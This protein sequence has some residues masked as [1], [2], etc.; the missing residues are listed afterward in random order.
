MIRRLPASLFLALLSAATLFA[1]ADGAWLAKVPAGDHQKTNPYQA[2]PDAIAAGRNIFE[3]HCSKCH[4][5]NA[6][7]RKKRPSLRSQRVQQQAT[8][9]DLHW[10]LVNGS[11]KKGMP[12]WAKLPDP[13]L[14]QLITYLKSLH[15]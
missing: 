13:Q 14:W 8:E 15:E 6:E 9:G 10:L 2:Q 3:E 4:G 12:S 1:T 5:E 11:M 7:G